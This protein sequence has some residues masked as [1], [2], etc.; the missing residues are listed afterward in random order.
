[1]K[2]HVFVFAIAGL[3]L[4]A[5]M[6]VGAPARSAVSSAASPSAARGITVAG[7][8]VGLNGNKLTLNTRNGAATVTYDRSTMF[9]RTDAASVADITAGACLTAMGAGSTG[10]ITA[11]VVQISPSVNGECAPGPGQGRARNSGSSGGAAANFM[12]VRGKVTSI[13][14]SAVTVQPTSGA[15][16]TVTIPATA[17]VSRTQ[18]AGSSQLAAG[19]CIAATGQAASSST[20]QARTVT[21]TAAGPSGCLTGG[22]GPRGRPSPITSSV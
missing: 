7:Q 11:N 6:G 17:R 10:A 16:V 8:L 21:I 15:A 4:A 1:M 3:A 20:V 22:F 19:Q 9:Q 2:V 12:A 14:G 18:A 5:C 13:S